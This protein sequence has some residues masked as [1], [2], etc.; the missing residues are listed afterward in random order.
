MPLVRHPE[1]HLIPLVLQV[2]LGQR[3]AISICGDD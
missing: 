2:A 3:A 1:S